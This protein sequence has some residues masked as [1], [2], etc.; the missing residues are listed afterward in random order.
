[1]VSQCKKHNGTSRIYSLAPIFPDLTPFNMYIW[2]LV[3]DEVYHPPMP[4]SLRERIL[5]AMVLIV[6][7]DILKRY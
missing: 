2:G 1:M 4:Q 7:F 3:K 5:Q 6:C